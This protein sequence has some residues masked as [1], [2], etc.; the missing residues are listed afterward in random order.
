MDDMAQK[1]GRR[2][3]GAER[4]ITILNAARKVLDRDGGSRSGLRAIATE[5]GCTTGAIYAQF[6]GK[7]EIYAALLEESLTALAQD[8]Q[9]AAAAHSDPAMRVRAAAWAF[10]AFYLSRPFEARLGLYLIEPDG[11]K[12]L[13]RA[14]DVVLNERLAASLHEIESGFLALGLPPDAA[15]DQ[16]Q[17]VFAGLLGIVSMALSHRDKS[18]GTTSERLF[19]TLLDSALSNATSDQP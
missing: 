3:A 9:A 14:R 1:P 16:M 8:V 15:R 6:S 7:D 4:R 2:Q 18:L 10:L 12:G 11:P 17:A 19:A 13:G 5:A